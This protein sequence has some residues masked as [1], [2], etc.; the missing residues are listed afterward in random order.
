MKNQFKKSEAQVTKEC[1]DLLKVKQIVHWRNNV[2]NGYFSAT[3]TGSRRYVR[4]GIAGLS[5]YCFL[6]NDGSGRTVYLEFK[7]STGKQ[8]QE[9]IDFEKS[10]TDR[11]VLYFVVS[12]VNDLLEILSMFGM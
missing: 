5:D 6:L 12:D 3:R 1:I 4:S 8:S 2:L 11:N 7:S 10:C 9:Q